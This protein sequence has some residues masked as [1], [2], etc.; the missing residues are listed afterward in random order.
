MEATMRFCRRM[1]YFVFALLSI[2]YGASAQEQ[3]IRIIYPFAA[4]GS[5]DGLARLVGDKMRAVL[6]RPVI[7][8]N[9]TGAAGRPGV[10]R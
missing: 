9:R 5:G 10:P 1:P 6:N 2:V 4:G 3:P 8:E 7:V